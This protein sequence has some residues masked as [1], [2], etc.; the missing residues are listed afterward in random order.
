MEGSPANSETTKSLFHTAESFAKSES[1][2]ETFKG[3]NADSESVAVVLVDSSGSTRTNFEDGSGKQ[4]F[5]KFCDIL[6]TLPHPKF[7]LI[8]W[9]SRRHTSGQFRDGILS[10]SNVTE[11]KSL[12]TVFQI[13]KPHI[14][15]GTEPSIAFRSIPA[16]WIKDEKTIIYL[17]T[18]GQYDVG[19]R[20][21]FVTEIRKLKNR[22]C[23]VAVANEVLD[24]SNLEVVERSCGGD[25][26]K[27]IQEQNLTRMVKNFESYTLKPFTGE[28]RRGESPAHEV[29]KVVQINRIQAPRG[30]VPFG[31]Q[32]FSELHVEEFMGFLRSFLQDPAHSDEASQLEV[33]QK[34]S[35][36]L[37]VLTKDKPKRV[38][39]GIIRS[40]A[41][42][43]TMDQNAILFI[44][45]DAVD[46]ERNGNAGVLAQYRADLKDLFKQADKLLKQDVIGN[47]SGDATRFMSVPTLDGHIL[48]GSHR[49]I[50]AT[51][52]ID[53]FKYPRGGFSPIIPVF[54]LITSNDVTRVQM[55]TLQ[56]QCLRQWVRSVVGKVYGVN[57][58]A[59]RVIY[60]VMALN[61]IAQK[62]SATLSE[63]VR[64]GFMNL[65]RVML[66]KKR[67]NSVQTTEY[68][69]LVSGEA[70]MP[71]SGKMTD[72]FADIFA[73]VKQFFPAHVNAEPMHV[74]FA[75]CGAFSDQVAAAQEKHCN[76]PPKDFTLDVT[77]FVQD[78]VPDSFS[79]DYSC[80]VTLDDVSQTGGYT[81]NPHNG[82]AG[83]C[84]PIFVISAEGKRQMLANPNCVCPVCYQRLNDQSFIEVGPKTQFSLPESFNNFQRVFASFHSNQRDQG[85]RRGGGNGNNNNDPVND[86]GQGAVGV[87]TGGDGTVT[88]ANGKKGTLIIMR[89]TV[90]C[91][92]STWSERIA[93]DVKKR[94]GSC[95]V[96]GTDKY[97]ARG[98]PFNQALDSVKMSLNQIAQDTNDDIV[99][100]IDTCGEKNGVTNVFSFD[101]TG[102]KKI[103]VFPNLDKKNM[104]GYFSWTLRNVLRRGKIDGASN[105]YLTPATAGTKTCIDVHLKKCKA[106]FPKD[107]GKLNLSG[108][109]IDS[110]S[111]EADNYEKT[112]LPIEIPTF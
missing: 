61:Y 80:I 19:I 6:E 95:Y 56:E 108:S 8:F 79:L 4:V 28:R 52:E 76:N 45:S 77:P 15:G 20:N 48:S 36:T 78:D 81:I 110:L 93:E 44:L 43:F 50:D 92:K 18:D 98:Q 53:K 104:R 39:D 103:E 107:A 24:L 49:L 109:T 32:F 65:V 94:G 66:N 41:S 100:I 26:Y 14:G 21:D 91:G 58:Q 90:G 33:A 46:R 106:L 62:S 35:I 12:R 2:G 3:V 70:P 87:R 37:E 25:V 27:L 42:L 99:V 63:D 85:Q 101:F 47:V 84:A 31:E 55:S 10:Y 11:K 89:G 29:Q 74:W 54:P 23:I 13:A 88:N 67:S 112:S 1:S 40:F 96:E 51:V 64:R 69:R 111:A 57:V 75:L 105:F 9:S 86:R 102:W 82:M 83:R 16:D 34:L 60:Y 38:A 68:D 72:L 30:Y 59:D 7:R 73:V 17:M 71:N 22:L 5:D 97:C